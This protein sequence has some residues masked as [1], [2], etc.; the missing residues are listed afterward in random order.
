MGGRKDVY[1]MEALLS[2]LPLM[3]KTAVI[4]PAER[5]VRDVVQAAP[6]QMAKG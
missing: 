4:I 1:G 6:V 2:S 5:V 3:E